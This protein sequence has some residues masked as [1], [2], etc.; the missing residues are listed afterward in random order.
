MKLTRDE[1]LALEGRELD[2]IVAKM[3][4]WQKIEKLAYGTAGIPPGEHRRC[5]IPYF[6]TDWSAVRQVVEKL[7]P[8]VEIGYAIEGWS[9]N[10]NQYLSQDVWGVPT[11]ELAV[12][13]AALLAVMEGKWT[14][15]ELDQAKVDAAE[16]MKTLGWDDG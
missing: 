8:Q 13:R 14:K 6:S 3:M 10:F 11:F 15:E 4:G 1:I 5:E 2:A 12:C 9:C 7:G 16:T